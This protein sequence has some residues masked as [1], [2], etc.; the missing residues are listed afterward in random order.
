MVV[1]VADIASKVVPKENIYIATDDDR[2]SKVVKDYDYKVIMTSDS[3][4]TGTDRVC[5][6]VKE[7]DSN[8]IV[9]IQ[10]DEPLMRSESIDRLLSAF[11]KD[12]TVQVAT[13]CFHSTDKKIY[14]NPN[15]VMREIE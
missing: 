7:I 12:R 13:L 6:A 9:N 14:L 3:C 5:E 1:R 2:I 8:I 11:H 15:V 4:L 10:G